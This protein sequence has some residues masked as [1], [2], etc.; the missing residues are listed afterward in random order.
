MERDFPE[1]NSQKM[2]DQCIDL[3]VYCNKIMNTGGR[4]SMERLVWYLVS[5][6]NC[7]NSCFE[8]KKYFLFVDIA[9]TENKQRQ[10][11][12]KQ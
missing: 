2:V 4:W 7:S 5:F 12:A 6:E 10:K 1:I 11:S 3:G 8:L 9:E